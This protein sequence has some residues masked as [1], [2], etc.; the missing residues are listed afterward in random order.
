MIAMSKNMKIVDRDGN[1]LDKPFCYDIDDNKQWRRLTQREYEY[2]WA[3]TWQNQQS[4]CAPSEDSDQPWHPSSLIRVFTVCMKKA[5]VLSYPLSAQRKLWS[6]WVDTQA[7]LSL[8]WAH[9]PFCWFCYDAAH[10]AYK[11]VSLPNWLHMIWATAWQN[12]QN[13][14]CTQQRPRSAWA[15]TQSDKNSL[16]AQWVAKDPRFRQVDSKDS[17]QSGWMPRLI[18]VVAGRTCHSVGFVMLRLI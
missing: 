1:I 10:F 14:L 5:W 3:A 9:M 7:D 17:D 16:C 2:K 12:Q 11:P 13:D 15:S 8:R 18:W 4:D 6:D